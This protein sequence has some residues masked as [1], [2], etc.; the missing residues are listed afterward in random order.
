MGTVDPIFQ[1]IYENIKQCWVLYWY[2]GLTLVNNQLD[3]EQFTPT[4]WCGWSACSPPTAQASPHDCNVT[5][6]LEGGCGT[7]SQ[8]RA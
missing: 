1:I 6:S 8:M 7:V 2:P 5:V 3:N 4:S